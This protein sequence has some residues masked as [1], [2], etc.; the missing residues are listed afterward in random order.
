MKM[1]SAFIIDVPAHLIIDFLHLNRS[2]SRRFLK[3]S[4]VADRRPP[5]SGSVPQT[6]P[7]TLTDMAALNEGDLPTDH[8]NL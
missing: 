3:G 6:E 8:S 1:M 4:L 5:G 7:I 2:G